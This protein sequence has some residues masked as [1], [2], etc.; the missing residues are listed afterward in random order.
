VISD[1]ALHLDDEARTPTTA[2]N[3]RTLRTTDLVGFLEQ[4]KPL[5]L[6]VKHRTG[7][8]GGSEGNGADP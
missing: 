5:V 8:R 7:P 1:E 2:P 3:V 4:D 6:D